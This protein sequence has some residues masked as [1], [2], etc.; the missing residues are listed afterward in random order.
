MT[1]IPD[2]KP[3]GL[4][5][6]LPAKGDFVMRRLPPAFV[7]AWDAWLQDGMTVSRERFGESWLDA[8]LVA[9]IW[10]FVLPPGLL[11]PSGVAGVLMPSIDRVGRY[12]PLTIAAMVEG[13]F[14]PALI[15][16]A[17][18]DWFTAAEGLAILALE[19]GLDFDRFDE[20]VAILGTP[21]APPPSAPI[22][23]DG[24]TW[25]LGLHAGMAVGVG[26][27]Q[28]AQE[29]LDGALGPHSVWWTAGS[30]CVPPCLVIRRG[31][32]GAADFPALIDGLWLPEQEAAAEERNDTEEPA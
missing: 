28:I 1:R 24:E 30:E 29:V 31:M 18:E 16:A 14:S 25:M 21:E 4:Y 9:P 7:D 5:G 26:M 3:C 2:D 19:D 22:L 8:Y 15:A 20:E 27:A 12:F 23:H 32:P 17:A 6:K 13:V 11:D 10:R